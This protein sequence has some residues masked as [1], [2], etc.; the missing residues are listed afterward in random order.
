MATDP[1][2][3][4]DASKCY[5]CY[6]A[7]NYN[8]ELIE[9]GLLRQILLA[10]NPVADTT[11]Q[12]LLAAAKCYACYATSNYSLGLL[13]LAL[14]VQIVNAGGTGGGGGQLVVYTGA[15]PTADGLTPTDQTKAAIA[16]KID[17][18]GPTYV[19]NTTTHVWN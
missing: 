17:G 18:T 11:P 3:L 7:S 5:E 2:T 13:R 14:L 8:L 4:I 1:Q 12:T 19:W 6:G 15:S 9:L 16:Y 10:S